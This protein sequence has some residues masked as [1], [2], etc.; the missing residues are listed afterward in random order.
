MSD[1][2]G[3]TDQN[4]DGTHAFRVAVAGHVCRKRDQKRNKDIREEF[5]YA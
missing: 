2:N 3:R 1:V 4:G 5:E